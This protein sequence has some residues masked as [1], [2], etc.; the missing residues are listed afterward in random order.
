MT[1][2]TNLAEQLREMTAWQK[3]PEVITDQQ[4]EEMIANGIRTLFIDTGRAAKYGKY[5]TIEQDMHL[6]F[7][8]DMMIDE[9]KYVMLTA[10]I[11]FFQRVQT[12]VNNIVSYT[13]DAL[14]VTQADKPYAHLQNS[15]NDLVNERRIVYYKMSRFNI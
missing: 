14:S 15:I 1:D 5:E 4:Y 9:E 13:T 7:T 10:Q 3:T 6:Y 11:L 12:D 8:Y 2:I